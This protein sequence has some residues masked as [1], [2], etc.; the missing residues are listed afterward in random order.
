MKNGLT[1]VRLMTG[2][3]FFSFFLARDGKAR[4]YGVGQNG[5]RRDSL[6]SG[7]VTNGKI[8]VKGRDKPRMSLRLWFGCLGK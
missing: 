3:S 1:G 8:G 7:T 4:N 6:R 2:G 5:E